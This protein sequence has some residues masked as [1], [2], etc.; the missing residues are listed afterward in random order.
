[1]LLASQGV[2]LEQLLSDFSEEPKEEIQR[3]YQE[4]KNLEK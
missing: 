2:P 1:M 4:A 3:W